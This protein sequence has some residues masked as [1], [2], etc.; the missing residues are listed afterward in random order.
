MKE[1]ISP[2]DQRMLARSVLTEIQLTDSSRVWGFVLERYQQ[3]DK[4]RKD[5]TI[6]FEELQTFQ[7]I[8]LGIND[9]F[10]VYSKEI[11]SSWQ[12]RQNSL[13]DK[14]SLPL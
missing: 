10:G 8:E 14:I 7:S 1:R 12:E 5:G 13:C 4:K 6:T 3:L 9:V 2:R 11:I